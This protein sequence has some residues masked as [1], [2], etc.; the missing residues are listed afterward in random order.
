MTGLGWWT[1]TVCIVNREENLDIVTNTSVRC[2]L[3]HFSLF[4]TASCC[5]C[6]PPLGVPVHTMHLMIVLGVDLSREIFRVGSALSL[7]ATLCC[8][9]PGQLCQREVVAQRKSGKPTL[10]WKVSKGQGHWSPFLY[11]VYIQS[12]TSRPRLTESSLFVPPILDSL[13]V[14]DVTACVVPHS[15]T[16]LHVQEGISEICGV[17]L[18]K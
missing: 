3:V 15:S 14:H 9:K 2:L 10:G 4:L 12:F 16:L 13:R 11:Y 6:G 7:C 18:S 5:T 8:E 17:L 1:G